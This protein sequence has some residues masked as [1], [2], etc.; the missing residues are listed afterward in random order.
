MRIVAKSRNGNKTAQIARVI[1]ESGKVR[2]LAMTDG[3][4]LINQYFVR[5]Y[6]AARIV[7]QYLH[8]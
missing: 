1:T 3:K 7:T 6:S 4:L 8:S 5:K 2:F